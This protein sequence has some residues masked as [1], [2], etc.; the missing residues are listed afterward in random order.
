MSVRLQISL[1]R[2]LV[3]N[4][5]EAAE[6]AGA[7]AVAD[8]LPE[9][10]AE[11]CDGLILSGGGDVDP[12]R[13]GEENAACFGVD[14]ERDE[15]EFRLIEA[16]IRAGKPILGICRGHQVLNVFF[17]GSLVQHLPTAEAHVPERTGDR[18]HLTRAEAGSFLAALYG[19]RF[20]VNS[21]HHQGIGRTAPELR[22][23][24]WTE[25]GVIEACAHV[26]LP[27]YSVQW[28]PERMC[29]GRARTDTVDGLALFSWFVDL[30][31][32]IRSV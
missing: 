13:Y 9:P 2:D 7:S 31:E 21:A 11:I 17:G 8:Y 29:L 19:E 10:M 20:R 32:K 12:G 25:D 16:Y 1:G 4:Y 27:V 18:A 23:V 26:S 15:A 14:P 28:H 6:A 24:Q 3:R 30:V 5:P 22:P